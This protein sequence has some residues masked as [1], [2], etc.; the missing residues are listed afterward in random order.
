MFGKGVV[1]CSYMI[2]SYQ[3]L[4]CKDKLDLRPS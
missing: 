1:Q 3:R 4:Y 2:Y